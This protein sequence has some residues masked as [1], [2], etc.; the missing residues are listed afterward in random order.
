MRLHLGILS[1]FQKS[2]PVPEQTRIMEEGCASLRQGRIEEAKEQFRSLLKKSPV[3]EDA[4]LWLTRTLLIQG[5]Y[6]EAQKVLFRALAWHRNSI[7]LRRLLAGLLHTT[8]SLWEAEKEYKKL[9]SQSNGSVHTFLGLAALT[10][11]DAR[12]DEALDWYTKAYKADPNNLAATLG[13]IECSKLTN[14]TNRIHVEAT[15]HV[16]S[17][18]LKNHSVVKSESVAESSGKY[19]GASVLVIDHFLPSTGSSAGSIHLY[20]IIKLFRDAG[21]HVTVIGRNGEYQ[22]R[23][24]MQLEALGAETYATDPDRLTAWN[25]KSKSEAIDFRQLLNKRQYLLAFL[26]RYNIADVYMDLLRK[27]VPSL[28][29]AIDS[30]D[31]HFVREKRK[32]LLYGSND[33]GAAAL[34]AKELEV[35][36]QAD[37]LIAVSDPDAKVLRE[38]FPDK[39]ICTLPL[40]YETNRSTAPFSERKDLLFVGNFVHPPNSDAVVYYTGRILPHLKSKL[41]GVK[42]YVVGANSIPLLENFANED[43]ILTGFVPTVQ[44]FLDSCRV[45][46]VPLRYGAG[47]NGK[48]LESMTA[49]VPVVTTPIVAEAIADDKGMMVAEDPED[50]ADAV[51]H[52]YQDE[53]LWNSIR[54]QAYDTIQKR[55][56]PSVV[57]KEIDELL[58]WAASRRGGSKT[59]SYNEHL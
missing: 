41:P 39:K 38:N 55:F 36:N 34:R 37:C 18:A 51:A 45:S 50:F 49:G 1:T 4:A 28:P 13:V 48:V 9:L 53:Q 40:I 25:Y 59:G 17:A 26:T 24:K 12:Y 11:G 46:V 32:E 47:M 35:Y 21:C 16:V 10:F 7:P 22:R 52:L 56:T 58:T 33:L 23:S 8:G 44:P 31:V 20:E 27:N 3:H 5:N 30:E 42:T 54:D 19:P 29:I 15:N 57:A 43:L 6:L 14:P 2:I